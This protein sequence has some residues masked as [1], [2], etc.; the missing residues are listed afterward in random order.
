[1]PVDPPTPVGSSVHPDPKSAMR[2]SEYTSALIQAIHAD[3]RAVKD[4]TALEIGFGSGVV[5]AA[6]A[7]LG[8]RSI[9]GVDIEPDA[10]V[11]G[12]RLLDELGVRAGAQLHCG[13]M[14]APV[15]DRRFDLIVANLPHFPTDAEDFPGRLPSW[16]AGGPDGRRLLD[17]F[18]EGL[19]AR[20]APG[21][22]ALVTHNVFI[23]LDRSRALAAAHGLEFR[24]A[25]TV[26]VFIPPDKLERMTQATL[27]RANGVSIRRFGPYAFGEVAVVEI[28]RS[29]ARA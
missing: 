14:W 16:S 17:P 25:L 7:R 24:T 21:G 4:A 10:V 18:L 6:L 15:A 12:G 27:R 13:D 19:E 28:A 3:A 23:G 5:L 20:L 1:M 11:Y 8:A 22:R 29:E 2:P 26:L 9:T